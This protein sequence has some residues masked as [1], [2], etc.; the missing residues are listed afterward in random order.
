MNAFLK[1]Q[2]VCIEKINQ[3]IAEQ[4]APMEKAARLLADS[5]MTGRLHHIFGS[6]GHSNMATEEMCYRAG[7][8]VPTNAI[9][10]PA[11]SAGV[12]GL[13]IERIP[14]AAARL[15]DFYHI[16]QGDLMFIVNANGVNA[17]TIDAA[18]ECRKRG[19]TSVALT[20]P[21]LSRAIPEG[22]SARHPSSQNL[23]D[24]A[25]V[26]IDSYTPYGEGSVE[27]EGMSTKV[28][29]TSTITNLFIINAINARA[30]ELMLESGFQPPVWISINIPGGDESNRKF[31]EQ[32]TGR[33]R[34][35]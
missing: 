3:I 9:F 26:V 31:V 24:L 23:C 1:Y 12:G 8:L 18:L 35:L 4:E 6:G 2:Q 15:F 5:V 25:D 20:T 28:S 29:P 33:L 19:V 14:G 13:C 30:C 32:Y 10:D 21:A 27:L 7:N 34:Y 11:I 17:M 16:S 22:T